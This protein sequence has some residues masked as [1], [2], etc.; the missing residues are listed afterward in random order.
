MF[1]SINRRYVHGGIA[2]LGFALL[3]G[4]PVKDLQPPARTVLAS[5]FLM[6]YLWITE[7][8]PIPV[9][10]LFPLV[11]FPLL[12]VMKAREASLPYANPNIFLFIG[13]FFIARAMEVH[14]LHRRIAL[15]LLRFLGFRPR[16]LVLSMMI[17]TAFLSM[18]ISNTATTM[19]ML[20]IVLS[21][22][23]GVDDENFARALLLG[24]AYA[25]SIGG[26]GTLIGTPPNLVL[27]GQL[28]EIFNV[29]LSF[30]AWLRTG[31]PVVLLFLPFTWWV[32]TG[33]LFPVQN[34]ESERERAIIQEAWSRLGAMRMEEKQVLAVF[35]FVAVLWV[36]RK[37]LTL[38]SWTLPGWAHLLGVQKTVHDA[39][40]AI[41][42][43]VL[44]FFL[45]DRKGNP[46]LSWEEAVRI[47]WG[48]VLLFGGGF[49]LAHA[50][51]IS[52]LA[53]WMGTR[54]HGLG[55]LPYPVLILMVALFTT[56]LTEL[57]SNT[58]TATVLLP[59]LAAVAEG[60]HQPPLPVMV[61]ATL[62]AS[63]AFMLPVATPPNAI[64]FGS[65]RLRVSDMARTGLVLNIAGSLLITLV[66]VF[67]RPL[68]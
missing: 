54:L 44:L 35:V 39:T 52:G 32:L 3:L 10:S 57:T 30:V 62:A 18:F 66:V 68:G 47:P 36:F 67:F 5:S 31:L 12:G 34:R 33:W 21:I 46:L 65:G 13:G 49:S 11:L 4:I 7:A 63:F 29:D 25:A 22:L 45:P 58:A 6:A 2:F 55:A 20:P 56:F 41:L 14:N 48:I 40:V 27:A 15:N 28:R 38:G 19:M 61:A 17:A 1:R 26:V 51:Q 59:I 24:V 37:D 43:A 23:H 9:T 42:G 60:I 16:T 50:F 8:L 64:V 53:Q